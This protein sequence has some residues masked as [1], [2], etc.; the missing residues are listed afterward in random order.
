MT[1]CNRQRMNYF[2]RMKYAALL[3]LYVLDIDAYCNVGDIPV[4]PDFDIKRVS[5]FVSKVKKKNRQRPGTETIRAQ[6]QPSKPKQEITKISIS[7][8]TKRT[9]SQPNEQL[10]PKR[11]RLSNPN[12]T[13]TNMDTHQVK[14]QLNSDTKTTALERSV[15]N[16][17]PNYDLRRQPRP[18]LLKWYKTFI[19]LF[20]PHEN[21]ITRQ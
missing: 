20:G 5:L 13:K 3:F 15:M 1:Y 7:Q 19:W 8:N 18:S 16:W 4:Q 12:R 14:R 21:P 2:E 10:F 11:W 17:G 9:Y 6:I